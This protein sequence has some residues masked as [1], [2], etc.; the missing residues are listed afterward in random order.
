MGSLSLEGRLRI[1]SRAFSYIQGSPFL[2]CGL[3]TF[4]TIDGDISS[5][6][7]LF[8]MGTPHAHNVYLQMAYDTGVPG[9]VAY[10]ALLFLAVHISWR[11]YKSTQG[12]S[13]A[14]AIGVLAALLA[15]HVYGLTDVV[16]L[17]AKPGVLWWALLAVAAAQDQL[18]VNSS[19][20]S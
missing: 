14:L 3:G 18:T 1:W 4:R 16:A 15:Y 13:R 19:D 20:Q 6:G 10:L 8:D 7:S 9:L 11:T 17:G 12:L 2:G 5:V